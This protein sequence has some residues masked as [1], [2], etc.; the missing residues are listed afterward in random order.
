MR[1][2]SAQRGTERRDGC[3]AYL[4]GFDGLDELLLDERLEAPVDDRLMELGLGLEVLR[5]DACVANASSDARS[6]PR[7]PRPWDTARY[8][9]V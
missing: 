2:D 4:H 8:T 7:V 5:P 3:G 6:R 9:E 1:H